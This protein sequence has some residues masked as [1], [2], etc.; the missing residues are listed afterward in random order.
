MIQNVLIIRNGIPVSVES[1]GQCHSIDTK[2]SLFAGFLEAFYRFSVEVSETEIE[3]VTF[4]DALINLK[5]IE[6][7]LF[8]IISNKEDSQ[9]ILASNLEQIIKLF[10][11]EYSPEYVERE[12]NIKKFSPFR[13]KL[14]ESRIVEETCGLDHCDLC[15]ILMEE[16][17]VKVVT[18]ELK[19]IMNKK[20][21]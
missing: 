8:I 13:K 18:S 20:I 4:K 17:T 12:Q 15:P 3:T 10:N 9:K 6:N 21:I 5:C 2:S 14:L 19:I 7:L 1:F 16:Q 11:N